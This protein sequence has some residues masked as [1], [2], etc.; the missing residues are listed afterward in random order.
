M[1]AGTDFFHMP[2][3]KVHRPSAQKTT[4]VAKALDIM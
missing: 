4:V 1:A 3:V 2:A